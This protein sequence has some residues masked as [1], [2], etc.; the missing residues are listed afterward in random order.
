MPAAGC[1]RE[2]GV[3]IDQSQKNNLAQEKESDQSRQ[4]RQDASDRPER[5]RLLQYVCEKPVQAAGC[6]GDLS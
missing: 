6:E 4:Q 3:E 1:V 5:R 2:T